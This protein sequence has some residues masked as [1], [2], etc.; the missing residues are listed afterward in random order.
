MYVLLEH[1]R[2]GLLPNAAN[3]EGN[4]EDG[5]ACL[6]KLLPTWMRGTHTLTLLAFAHFLLRLSHICPQVHTGSV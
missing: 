1:A 2:F 3:I 5:C 6:G 4:V